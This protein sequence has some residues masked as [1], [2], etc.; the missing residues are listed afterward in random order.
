VICQFGPLWAAGMRFGLSVRATQVLI[1]GYAED[2]GEGG[3]NEADG[4]EG[5]LF[6]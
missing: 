5:P 2:A 4:S 6:M 1:E 3:V